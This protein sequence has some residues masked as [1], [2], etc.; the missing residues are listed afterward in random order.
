MQNKVIVI[1]GAFGALG[2]AV[3]RAFSNQGAAVAMLD[4]APQVPIEFDSLRRDRLALLPGIDITKPDNAKAAMDETA[5]MFGGI[6]VLVNLAGGFR[7]QTLEDGS[8]AIWDELYSLNLKTAVVATKAALPHLLARGAG[9]VINVGAES[10]AGRA[11]AGMGAYAASKAGVQRL[12]ESLAKELRDRGITVN[13][14]LPGTI[15]T[16]RN[17]A[18]MPKANF[19]RWV[20]PAEL[21]DVIIFF[22]SDAA[23]AVTGA[24]LP[25]LGRG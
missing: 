21:A 23:R 6:D 17:R 1:T 24:A 10:A 16:D 20:T 15:D 19:A 7:S 8:V 22:A 18:E 9:R 2:T 13:V 25:V 4:R 3:A 11:A 5:S 14:V 12:T